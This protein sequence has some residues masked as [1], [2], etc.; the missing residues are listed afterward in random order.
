MA[1]LLNKNKR[2]NKISFPTEQFREAP[3][4]YLLYIYFMR[5]TSFRQFIYPDK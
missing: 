1:R 3:I 5:Y 2:P 4:E